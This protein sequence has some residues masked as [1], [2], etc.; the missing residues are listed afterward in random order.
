MKLFQITSML[1]F[2][3]FKKSS[4]S[5]QIFSIVIHLRSQFEPCNISIFDHNY[6]KNDSKGN[7]YRQE[8]LQSSVPSSLDTDHF[9]QSKTD[10]KTSNNSNNMSGMKEE[11]SF[12]FHEDQHIQEPVSDIYAKPK[13]KT[14]RFANKHQNKVVSQKETK[15]MGETTTNLRSRPHDPNVVYVTVNGGERFVL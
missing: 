4:I 9:Y 1:Y 12:F 11:P 2:R 7:A 8:R 3:I 13:P 6:R 5:K 15:Q 10:V 14:G